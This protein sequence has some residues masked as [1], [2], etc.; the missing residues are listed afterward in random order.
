MA[1]VFTIIVI[2]A[3]LCLGY[4]LFEKDDQDRNDTWRGY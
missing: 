2:V 3:V 4:Y 1:L